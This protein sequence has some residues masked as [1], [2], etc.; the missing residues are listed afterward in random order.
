MGRFWIWGL[1]RVKGLKARDTPQPGT[2]P[3]L[4]Y[5]SNELLSASTLQLAEGTL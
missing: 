5:V 1:R 4:V 2:I 3:Y